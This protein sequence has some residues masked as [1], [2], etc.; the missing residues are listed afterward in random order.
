MPKKTE[1][2]D[3]LGYFNIHSVAKRQKQK[4]DPWWEKNEKKSHSAEKNLKG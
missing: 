3:P 2:E 1:T 4:R